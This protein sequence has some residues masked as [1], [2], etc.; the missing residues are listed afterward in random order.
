MEPSR[1]GFERAEAVDV[2][3]DM[4]A[5]DVPKLSVLDGVEL[6]CKDVVAQVP[7]VSRVEKTHELDR[8]SAGEISGW[9]DEEG[10][11]MASDVGEGREEAEHEGEGERLHR[12]VA[13]MAK[14]KR[15]RVDG[16]AFD[17]G[18]VVGQLDEAGRRD[19]RRAV[20]GEVAAGEAVVDELRRRRIAATDSTEF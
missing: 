18:R 11:A 17:P 1:A 5:V 14:A 8:E 7:V 19:P 9:G 13:G 10:K 3:A 12:A 4:V 15:G 20:Q 16:M 2:D 6:N